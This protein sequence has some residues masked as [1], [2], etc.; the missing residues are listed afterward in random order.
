MT[1]VVKSSGDDCGPPRPRTHWQTRGGHKT[2]RRDGAQREGCEEEMRWERAGRTNPH[3][4]LCHVPLR[5]KQNGERR[6]RG[7]MEEDAKIEQVSKVKFA[8]M[9]PAFPTR[10]IKPG[11]WLGLNYITQLKLRFGSPS[12]DNEPLSEEP[13]SRDLD[14]QDETSS[15]MDWTHTDRPTETNFSDSDTEKTCMY[16]PTISPAY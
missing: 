12:A 16:P 4:D 10:L 13:G 1:L 5:S 9:I 3:W 11:L 14:Y 8:S 6:E 7:E 2:D 15:G